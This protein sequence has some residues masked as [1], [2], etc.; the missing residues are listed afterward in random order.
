MEQ[1][2][3]RRLSDRMVPTSDNIGCSAAGPALFVMVK[4]V[5]HG[6]LGYAQTPA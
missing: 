3:T 2:K 5:C 6:G 1:G 4:H